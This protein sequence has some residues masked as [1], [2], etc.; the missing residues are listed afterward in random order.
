MT[1]PWEKPKLHVLFRGK[2]EE[3][4]LAVCKTYN[5]EGSDPTA[6]FKDCVEVIIPQCLKCVDQATS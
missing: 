4:V 5:E 2:P 1:I 3:R 6:T